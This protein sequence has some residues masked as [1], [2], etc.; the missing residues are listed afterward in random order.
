MIK[1]VDPDSS[2][3]QAVQYT[4]V[5]CLHMGYV[6]QVCGMFATK[7]TEKRD[8]LTFEMCRITSQF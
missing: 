2:T 5:D 1:S 3:M 6:K 7:T 8:P 4:W